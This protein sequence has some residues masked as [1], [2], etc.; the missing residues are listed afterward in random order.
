MLAL[1]S[2]GAAY[3]LEFLRNVFL[4]TS[5]LTKSW[6]SHPGISQVLSTMEQWAGTASEWAVDFASGAY[7]SAHQYAGD[8][9]LIVVGSYFLLLLV[10]ATAREFSSRRKKVCALYRIIEYF[11]Y[12]M[13]LNVMDLLCGT[14]G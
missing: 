1:N 10:L 9:I 8:T 11:I 13:Y 3:S 4:R 14:S 7:A 12:V 2:P 5:N 6:S